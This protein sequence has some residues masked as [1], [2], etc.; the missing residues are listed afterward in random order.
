MNYLKPLLAGVVLASFASAASAQA[1]N[2]VDAIP[3]N[4]AKVYRSGLWKQWVYWQIP[5]PMAYQAIQRI[6]AEV[7]AGRAAA[8]QPLL[9][10]NPAY[11][12]VASVFD[13]RNARGKDGS[14]ATPATANQEAFLAVFVDDTTGDVPVL[15][16]TDPLRSNPLLAATKGVPGVDATVQRSM[17]MELEGGNDSVST[18]WDVSSAAGDRI[19]FSAR[20]D[21]AAIF[22]TAVGPA[23]RVAYANC[24]LTYST[25]IVFRSTPQ[26]THDLFARE[27]GNFI[28]PT[29]KHV[30]V[31]LKVKHHDPDVHAIFNDPANMPELLF[32]LDRDVRVQVR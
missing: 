6:V 17:S 9:I 3:Q 25:S 5:G 12:I 31:K 16:L 32:G 13:E 1:M 20:Y 11:E 19:K 24:N 29:E 21:S 26:L 8:G 18:E 2:C 30:H 23:T 28:D 27:Q 15:F 4:P 10:P 22:F 14:S 7:N